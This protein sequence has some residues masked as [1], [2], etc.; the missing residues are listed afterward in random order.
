MDLA[1]DPELAACWTAWDRLRRPVWMFDPH[2]LKGVYA[3][4]AALALW[5]A[6]GL[7]ELLS[8]DFSQLSP[9]VLARTARLARE[10]ADGRELSERWTFYPNGEPV[11]VQAMISTFRM[12]DGRSVLLFEATPTE[13][14]AG[15]RRA[16][17]ALRNTA[18]LITLFDE[19]GRPVFANPAAFAAYGSSE[20]PFE[21]RFAE[22]E[23]AQPLLARC[24]EG[25]PAV[26]LCR[27]V[28]DHGLRWHQMDLR[29]VLD[30]VTGGAGVLLNES[31]VT[32]RVEAEQARAAAEQK[33][34][35]AEARQRFLTEMSH[36]LR[37]PLNAVLGFSDLLVQSRLP[38]QARDQARRIKGA[39]E[40][41]LSVV[42][43]MIALSE[44]DGWDGRSEEEPAA[45]EPPAA[46][47][48]EPAE[49]A[50]LRVLYVDDND[51]NR[52]LVRAM[53]TGYGITCQTA[54]DGAQGLEAARAGGWDVILMDI[55]MPV[56]D[57]VSAARAI[58]ALEAPIGDVPI[59]A[60]TA[61]TLQ[62]Q[63]DVYAAAGMND[64]LAKPVQMA[65]LI[66]KVTGWGEVSPTRTGA[67]GLAA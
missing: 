17:E 30:P 40:R 50:P 1:T 27:V 39:G 46:E 9:A 51:S 43:D 13:V 42:N 45:P 28:T 26:E 33:A 7:E 49:A 18:T 57:G 5:G 53:L 63:L 12:P 36:E 20:H 2:E 58:R 54:D 64:C 11:T 22:P 44:L 6:E 37:T 4:R 24:L 66:Q 52:A 55:Q 21:R 59:I 14:E 35:M 61:N 31:D 62:E 19:A 15:E 34:A 38:E 16:V 29:P 23:R 48:D 10:T 41:L 25:E 3:N 8:R 47:P 32:E 56:M 65:S 60:L 67:A